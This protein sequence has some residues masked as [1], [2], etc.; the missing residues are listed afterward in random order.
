[1]NAIQDWLHRI[2]DFLFST[3]VESDGPEHLLDTQRI[4]SVMKP[5]IVLGLFVLAIDCGAYFARGLLLAAA[6]VA[7]GFFAGFVFGI[8]R[9]LQ[10]DRVPKSLKAA[11][12]EYRQRVNTNLEDISDWITKIIVGLG[13]YELKLLSNRFSL[14]SNKTF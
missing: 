13:L 7:A 5:I 9:V 3:G 12:G 2:W 11:D 10:V 6:C 4:I 1:M 8:P 14:M